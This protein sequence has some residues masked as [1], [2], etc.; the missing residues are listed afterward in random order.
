V[1]TVVSA[2]GSLLDTLQLLV[3]GAS[4][5]TLRQMLIQDR[6]SLN[7]VVCRKAVHQVQPGDLI[8]IGP[9]RNAPTLPNELE[10]VFEDD[11]ILVVNKPCG[12][13][14]VSTPSEREKT[15]YALLSRCLKERNPGEALYIVHRID[16]FASGLLVFAKTGEIQCRLK[17][18]LST[19]EIRRMYWAIVEGIVE[20]ERGT[21]RSFLAEDKTFHVHS[22]RDRKQGKSAVT[23]YRTLCRFQDISTLE[24]TLETGRKNQIRVHLS[25]IGHPV[26]GDRA[27]GR[28]NDPLG[29][30]GLHAFH[31]GFIHPTRG[32]P[33]EYTAE[34]PPEFLPYLP[35]TME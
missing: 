35:K 24:V 27:Y 11:A 14:S 22:V 8:E 2:P 10:I 34:P 17:D 33:V 29:R 31:L 4:R 25:E 15:V 1:K 18:L 12:L 7:G 9:R 28:G 6:I 5:R 20:Q 30:L 32:V 13:L 19:H 21:V 16:K 3:P 23:H 26:V